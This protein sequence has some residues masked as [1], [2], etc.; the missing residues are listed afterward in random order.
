MDGF[1]PDAWETVQHLLFSENPL[2]GTCNQRKAR[3]SRGG[4]RSAAQKQA[5]RNRAQA[6]RGRN[7]MDPATRSEAAKK[8][9]ATRAKCGTK[10]FGR[11]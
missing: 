2:A 6:R 5:D 11:K 7:H 8:A 10:A 1:T 3:Q 4:G 9:A